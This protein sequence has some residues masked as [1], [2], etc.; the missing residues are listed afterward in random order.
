MPDLN[1]HP[2]GAGVDEGTP[3]PAEQRAVGAGEAKSARSLLK[4]LDCLASSVGFAPAHESAAEPVS[5][6]MV[7]DHEETGATAPGSSSASGMDQG[8][9]RRIAVH[10]GAASP[11][12]VRLR[13]RSAATLPTYSPR[14]VTEGVQPDPKHDEELDDEVEEP[15]TFR[16]EHFVKQFALHLLYPFSLTIAQRWLG[17]N[18][19]NQWMNFPVARFP[20]MT[21]R[22]VVVQTLT[23]NQ[24]NIIPIVLYIVTCLKIALDRDLELLT[25]SEL[26]LLWLVHVLRIVIVAVKYGFMPLCVYET[27]TQT[28]DQD[29]VKMHMINELLTSWMDPTDD[30]IYREIDLAATERGFQQD[31]AIQ[32]DRAEFHFAGGADMKRLLKMVEHSS[33][34]R[35]ATCVKMGGPGDVTATLRVR[36]VCFDIYRKS[37]NDDW[38]NGLGSKLFIYGVAVGV[39]GIPCLWRADHYGWSNAVGRA[40]H[41]LEIVL[42]LPCLFM[43]FLFTGTNTRFMM[44][45]LCD[46][47]RR[48]VSLNL[49]TMLIKPS[50]SLKATYNIPERPSNVAADRTAAAPAAALNDEGDTAL[51]DLERQKLRVDTGAAQASNRQRRS[52]QLVR[53]PAAVDLVDLGTANATGW[54]V[55]YDTLSRVGRRFQFRCQVVATGNIFLLLVIGAKMLIDVWSDNSLQ[56]WVNSDPNVALTPVVF[57]AYSLA[58]VLVV[59]GCI[60][61]GHQANRQWSFAKVEIRACQ[62]E[63]AMIEDDVACS[64]KRQQAHGT[65]QLLSTI[66]K[67]MK[68]LNL[69]RPIQIMGIRADMKLLASV[70]TAFVSVVGLVSQRIASVDGTDTTGSI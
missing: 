60:I 62:R 23:I 45:C 26:L 35:A 12:A 21:R 10:D 48:Y 14:T 46:F 34:C 38:L 18:P 11:G 1:R 44:V 17:V 30:M 8:S 41:P 32:F 66:A 50:F 67:E 16:I 51:D 42:I 55:L 13:A 43:I 24:G 52:H 15:E 54:F 59:I 40:E 37:V 53:H 64:N 49:A 56:V 70:G 63:L 61:L 19:R 3:P 47:Q 7:L 25:S 33:K 36:E 28:D 9:P 58:N 6:S 5:L 22:D 4:E 69:M 68:E 27:V 65:L 20:G 31:E 39:A 29:E 2:G 57:F